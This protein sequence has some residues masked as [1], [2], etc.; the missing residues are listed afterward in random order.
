MRNYYDFNMILNE[1]DYQA[2][3]GWGFPIR[4]EG[5]CEYAVV[6]ITPKK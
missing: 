5:I 3:V 4:T 2:F 6:N 1:N